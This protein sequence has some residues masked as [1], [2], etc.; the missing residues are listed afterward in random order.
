M[1]GRLPRSWLLHGRGAASKQC[2]KFAWD[3]TEF[4]G[5][6]R[7][8]Y[9]CFEGLDWKKREPTFHFMIAV[10]GIVASRR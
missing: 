3:S 6:L 5:G 2:L 1:C 10:P 9:S 8:P 7:C 4:R